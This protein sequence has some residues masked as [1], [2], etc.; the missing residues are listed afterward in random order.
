M[1]KICISEPVNFSKAV[2]EDLGELGEVYCHNDS[3]KLDVAKALQDYDVFWCRLGYSIDASHINEDTRCRWIVCPA[4]GLDH[5]DLEACKAHGIEV[6]SL[7]NEYEFLRD[8]RATAEHTLCL[9][10]M[11]LRRSLH[12]ANHVLE[13]AWDRYPFL[14][15]E[16]YGKRVGIL[17]YGRLG[18]L[19]AQLFQAFGADVSYYDP[20]VNSTQNSIQ[21]IEHLDQ[22]I[23]QSHLISVHLKLNIETEKF[24]NAAFLSKMQ[25]HAY[26]VNTSRGAIIDEVALLNSLSEGHLAGAA[27]DVVQNESTVSSENALIQYAKNNQNLILTPHIGGFTEESI[28]KTERFMFKKLLNTLRASAN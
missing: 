5:I 15:N 20:Y 23:A 13:G 28:D 14:G 2:L 11:L 27:L 7:A 22:F 10:L 25:R 21:R 24:V 26:L 16:I 9:C 18:Q 8:I 6:L 3:A 19:V 12:A 1:L 4:T 17:G